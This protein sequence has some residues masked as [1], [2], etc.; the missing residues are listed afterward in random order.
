MGNDDS[1]K[2]IVFDSL[3]LLLQTNTNSQ[4]KSIWNHL[5]ERCSFWRFFLLKCL[6]P[7]T[8][9]WYLVSRK[10]FSVTVW[11]THFGLIMRHGLIS[12]LM[13]WSIFKAMYLLL[14]SSETIKKRSFSIPWNID[15]NFHLY[16]TIPRELLDSR[17]LL[18]IEHWKLTIEHWTLY[19]YYL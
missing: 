16:Y 11:K 2:R 3:A 13:L 15:V 12:N 17:L 14:F 1:S 10:W 18:T 4:M 19:E 6:L 5:N 9:G 8:W 7:F